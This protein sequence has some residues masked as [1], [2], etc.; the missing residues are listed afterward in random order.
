M[1]KIASFYNDQLY[2][3]MLQ[4]PTST[5]KEADILSLLTNKF[6]KSK[7]TMLVPFSGKIHEITPAV[8]PGD[9]PISI[10]QNDRESITFSDSMGS[11]DLCS[12]QFTLTGLN[13]EIS[14]R[15]DTQS[16]EKAAQEAKKTLSRSGLCG[17][18]CNMSPRLP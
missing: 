15:R 12:I 10:W 5:G 6:G 14:Q 11:L 4:A 8:M 9:K 3:I 7:A 2:S 13:D 16:R 17:R 1:G 18:R